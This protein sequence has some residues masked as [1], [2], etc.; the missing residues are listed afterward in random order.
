MKYIFL[1]V[2]VM[3]FSGC[4]KAYWQYKDK[5]GKLYESTKYD[6]VLDFIADISSETDVNGVVLLLDTE[7]QVCQE[8]PVENNIVQGQVK[9]Y[10]NNKLFIL[11]TYTNGVHNGIH[12]VWHDNGILASISTYSNGCS[13]WAWDSW[14]DNGAKKSESY[15]IDKNLKILR[16]RN[17]D[18][19]GNLIAD[20]VSSN[21]SSING[22]FISEQTENEPPEVAVFTNGVLVRRY[23]YNENANNE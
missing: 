5:N 12:K 18:R 17:W 13:S 10:R 14:Y 3:F 23:Y 7:D 21:L 2:V 9:F 4:S 19:R 22:S 11:A 8:T 20:G 1:I 15:W 6:S 16:K